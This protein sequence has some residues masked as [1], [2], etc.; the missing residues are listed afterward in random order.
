MMEYESPQVEEL[1]DV[2]QLTEGRNFSGIDGNSQGT[3]NGNQ[4]NS[5]GN[6]VGPGP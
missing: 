1:G 4:G 2:E 5:G 6:G 3:S